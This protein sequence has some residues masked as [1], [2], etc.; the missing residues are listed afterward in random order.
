MYSS[1]SEKQR[2]KG[3]LDLSWADHRL[4]YFPDRPREVRSGGKWP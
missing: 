3:I 4:G 1:L 2:D